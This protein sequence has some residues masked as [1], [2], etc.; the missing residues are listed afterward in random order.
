MSLS[1]IIVNWN[2]RDLLAQA[3]QSVYD[4]AQGL[5]FEVF[6]VDNASSDGSA[7]MVRE[8]FPD[9][10]LIENAE[11]VGFARAN[12]QAIRASAGEYVLLLNSDARVTGDCVSQMARLMDERADVGIVGPQLV[13]P[14]GRPQAA[15]GPLPS[16]AS[17]I[18]SLFGLD[19]LGWGGGHRGG[20]TQDFRETGYVA[21]A[22]MMIRRRALDEVG[23]LDEGYFM[24][25]EEIDLCYR[26]HQAGWKV[27][28]LPGALAIH[29]GGGSTGV[30]PERILRLYRGKLQYFAKHHGDRSGRML[31]TAMR[32]AT[33]VKV[34]GYTLLRAVSG[35]RVQKDALWREVARELGS[36][37]P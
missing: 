8:R 2:T 15:C 22:C 32:I 6:V 36:L 31:L 23:L 18:R 5:A 16:L 14:D 34:V 7:A 10:R 25:S 29:V 13:Y 17:E 24:F 1:I 35:G 11:N 20:S 37:H 26:A 3:L 28:H 9:V 12:N 33:G 4:T 30:T 19:R 21:G 27:M